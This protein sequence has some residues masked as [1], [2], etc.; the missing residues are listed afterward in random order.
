M[1]ADDLRRHQERQERDREAFRQN[2]LAA[3]RTGELERRLRYDDRQLEDYFTAEEIDEFHQANRDA[4]ETEIR[5]EKERLD[6]VTLAEETDRVLTE[7]DRDEQTKRRR[8]AEE[9][10]RERIAGRG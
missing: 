6:R 5:R 9:V 10:A 3:I 2:I 8:K 4:Q 7:W 1:L